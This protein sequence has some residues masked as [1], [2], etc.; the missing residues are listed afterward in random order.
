MQYL[1]KHLVLLKI[2]PLSLYKNS[3]A[4]ALFFF[5]SLLQI[6]N[7]LSNTKVLSKCKLKVRAMR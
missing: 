4:A 2:V 7:L 3:D 5:I 6:Y 1:Y